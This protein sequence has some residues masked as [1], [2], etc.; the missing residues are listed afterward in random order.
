MSD[1]NIPSVPRV[2]TPVSPYFKRR[3]FI[4]SLEDGLSFHGKDPITEILTLMDDPKVTATTKIKVW[5]AMFP[6][7]YAKVTTEGEDA[8]KMKTREILNLSKEQ[9]LE[10]LRAQISEIETKE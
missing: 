5:L 10:K 6:Y 4:A 2:L 8:V 3:A 1:E 7:L 9:L